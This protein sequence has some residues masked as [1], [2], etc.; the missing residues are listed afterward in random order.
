MHL[1][2]RQLQAEKRNEEAFAVF[3]ENAKKHPDLWFVHTGLARVY[4][5]QGKFDDAAKEMKLSLAVAPDNQKSYLD[6]LEKR[7]ESKQ[8]INQ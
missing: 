1:Y 5:S 2:G 3:R 8:D 6:G 7:L 4:S